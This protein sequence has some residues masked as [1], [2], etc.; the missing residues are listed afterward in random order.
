MV[1]ISLIVFTLLCSSATAQQMM[2]CENGVCTMVSAA[3]TAEPVVY[4]VAYEPQVVSN[5]SAGNTIVYRS[6]APYYG[7]CGGDFSGYSAGCGGNFSGYSNGC[8]GNAVGYSSG[9]YGN[10]YSGY[11]YGSGR[12]GW[13]TGARRGIFRGHCCG[14]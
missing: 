9:Y 8:G 12:R 7:N 13:F 3:I 1:R 14:G 2:V 6:S 10:P 5:G 11:G 4:Q